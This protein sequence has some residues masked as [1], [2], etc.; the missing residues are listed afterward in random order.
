M[1]S[2]IDLIC[3]S[4]ER[5]AARPT[6]IALHGAIG[7]RTADDLEHASRR[8]HR[9]ETRLAEIASG[10][11]LEDRAGQAKA[12]RYS[13]TA[14][15]GLAV[16][17]VDRNF[18]SYAD[19]ASTIASPTSQPLPRAATE[20]GLWFETPAAPSDPGLS[21]AIS[22]AVPVRPS[23]HGG[24][25][26]ADAQGPSGAFDDLLRLLATADRTRV[27]SAMTEDAPWMGPRFIPP[28]PVVQSELAP[29]VVHSEPP[30]PSTV[31]DAGAVEV[32]RRSSSSS[33][34]A[35]EA[36]LPDARDE[37]V[38]AS[39][40]VRRIAHNRVGWLG[41]AMRRL[42]TADPVLAGRAMT[43]LLAAQGEVID[44]EVSYDLV[45]ED[46]SCHAVTVSQDEVL[47]QRIRDCGPLAGRR[48][49]IETDLYG[50]GLLAQDA[51]LPRFARRSRV[52]TSGHL[53][54]QALA[55]LKALATARIGLQEL[56]SCGARVEHEVLLSL[57]AAAIP[58]DWTIGHAFTIAFEDAAADVEHPSTFVRINDGGALSVN[59]TLPLDVPVAMVRCTVDAL[60]LA[61]LG[62]Q[63]RDGA[64]AKLTGDRSGVMLL[65][66]WVQRLESGRR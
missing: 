43:Q 22:G 6:N 17:S 10:K 42:A 4:G 8:L 29:S 24:G 7:G 58:T 40:E 52:R 53:A 59:S 20:P 55:A 48:A 34:S 47:V 44:G 21:L 28:A 13:L 33:Q 9:L 62:S 65:Q 15:D 1:P 51:R 27:G 32:T 56:I 50:L 49:R 35:V 54:R 5:S 31:P 64:S 25:M 61:L 63:P 16:P 30:A 18:A 46:F 23:P 60:P 2:S 26:P 11:A 14:G 3:A 57:V 12:D 36:I 19:A 39:A 38:P 37:P 45:V 41:D 66:G